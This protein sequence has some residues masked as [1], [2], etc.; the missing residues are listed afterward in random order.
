M[1]TDD[2][3]HSESFDVTQ[4]L[5]QGVVLSPLQLSMFFAAVTHVALVGFG[6]DEGIARGAV[7]LEEDVGVGKRDAVDM[8]A[9]GSVRHVVR[10]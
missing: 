10:R 1:R 2:G 8:R 3:E 4:G 6:E 5:R 9:K 7:H